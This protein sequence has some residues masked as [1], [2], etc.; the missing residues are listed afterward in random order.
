MSICRA[1]IVPIASLLIL[2]VTLPVVGQQEKAAYEIGSRR[3]LMLDDFLFTSLGG[4]NSPAS[5]V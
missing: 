3:E 1:R 5:R 4:N 2:L